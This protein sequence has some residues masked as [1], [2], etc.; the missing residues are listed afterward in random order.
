MVRPDPRT[1]PVEFAQ[2]VVD[3]YRAHSTAY[4]T[5]RMTE[6]VYRASL[7]AL[8]WRGRDINTECAL[9]APETKHWYDRRGE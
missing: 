4:R 6:A 5:G 1:E 9:N 7:H 2:F 8:G 3:S